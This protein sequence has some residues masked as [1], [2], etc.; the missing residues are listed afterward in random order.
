MKNVN[1]IKLLT[2]MVFFMM[3]SCV[4]INIYFPAEKVNKVADEIAKEVRGKEVKEKT[5]PAP[6]G[7]KEG[8]II[9]IRFTSLF[10]PCDVYAES[11]T[12]VSNAVIRSI[13][14][15]MKKRFPLLIPYFKAGNIGENN[16]GFLALRNVS[17]LSVK[18]RARLNKLVKAENKD[19]KTLYAEVAKALNIAPDQVSRVGKIFANKWH[20]TCDKGWW[21]QL[22]DGTWTKKQ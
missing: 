17:G 13:K 21:I 9:N 4:T 12:E 16:Q 8:L 18:Q 7:E 10:T 11:A 6:K 20:E 2:V 5:A 15:R 22:D 1:T 3:F 19:R 14:E